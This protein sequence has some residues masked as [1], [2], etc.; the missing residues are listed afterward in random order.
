MDTSTSAK[1]HFSLTGTIEK[2]ES[3]DAIIALADG[4]QLIW[5]IK[6]LP[7]DAAVNSQVTLFLSTA[8]TEQV[9]LEKIAKRVLNTILKSDNHL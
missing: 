5:P 9:E 1:E 6:N 8:K 3:K 2:F 7:E 4:Q